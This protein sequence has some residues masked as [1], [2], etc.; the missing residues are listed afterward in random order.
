MTGLEA[1]GYSRAL[2]VAA[3]GKWW[4]RP[5][6]L[7]GVVSEEEAI[8]EVLGERAADGDDEAGQ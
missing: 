8:A 4:L 6:G 7:S 3:P 2:W 1:V 5:G